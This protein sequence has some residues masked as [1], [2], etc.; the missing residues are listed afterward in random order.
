MPP[1]KAAW[2]KIASN[3]NEPASQ[4]ASPAQGA[5]SPQKAAKNAA[6]PTMTNYDE[7]QKN[8]VEVLRSIYMDDFEDVSVKPGA[9]NVSLLIKR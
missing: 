2:S 7:I 9:W 3:N 8:E 6:N 1:R 5:K 4:S